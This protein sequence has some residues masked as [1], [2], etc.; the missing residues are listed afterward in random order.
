M[1]ASYALGPLFLYLLMLGGWGLPLG[2]PPGPEDPVLAK[3]APQECLVYLS[4]AGTA[5]PEALLRGHGRG[6]PDL[7]PLGPAHALGVVAGVAK[8]RTAN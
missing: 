2:I 5:R 8:R 6:V 3:V 4:W 1:V 7:L